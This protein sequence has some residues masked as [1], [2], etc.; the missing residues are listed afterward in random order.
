MASLATRLLLDVWKPAIAESTEEVRITEFKCSG[1][2]PG[3][4]H[5]IQGATNP[6][7]SF[8]TNSSL[9]NRLADKSFTMSGN[10]KVSA[11]S[12]RLPYL[13]GGRVDKLSGYSG[14]TDFAIATVGPSQVPEELRSASTLDR[15]VSWI[16]LEAQNIP[17]LGTPFGYVRQGARVVSHSAYFAHASTVPMIFGSNPQFMWG[18][19]NAD[20][21]EPIRSFIGFICDRH[22]L[23]WADYLGICSGS[24]STTTIGKSRFDEDQVSIPN[25]R[26]V[27][28]QM[29]TTNN[30][31]TLRFYVNGEGDDI[32]I[33]EYGYEHRM[34]NELNVMFAYTEDVSLV[35]TVPRKGNHLNYVGYYKRPSYEWLLSGPF[36]FI[37]SMQFDVTSAVDEEIIIEGV[38]VIVTTK[39]VVV[40]KHSGSVSVMELT[41]YFSTGYGVYTPASPEQLK[42]FKK[43]WSKVSSGVAFRGEIRDMS[44][45]S[46][47]SLRIYKEYAKMRKKACKDND[48]MKR[49]YNDLFKWQDVED[50]L[51]AASTRSLWFVN[52]DSVT[53]APSIALSVAVTKVGTLYTLTKTNG[54][55]YAI[56]AV[57][58][59]GDTA[60]AVETNLTAF[61]VSCR[62]STGS[63]FFTELLQ[64]V[65][66]KL[67]NDGNI[68]Q[69]QI[70]E[71]AV[72][73]SEHAQGSTRYNMTLG[74]TLDVPDFNQ[75]KGDAKVTF[76]IY[77]VCDFGK[78]NAQLLPLF[79]RFNTNLLYQGSK[80][81]LLR[82]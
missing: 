69:S 61:I 56:D 54:D 48:W 81:K 26:L 53:I 35:W 31:R 2:L 15:S 21:V 75:L 77:Q 18:L 49:S 64:L 55:V 6:F 16:G 39:E 28:L 22:G 78:M 58:V 14:T 52:L 68:D 5:T 7:S 32:Y 71:L 20:N 27:T 38:K 72:S 42:E 65:S 63:Q 36:Q 41:D 76:G 19:E 13:P 17:V 74:T 23:V 10:T 50:R 9:L 46:V 59:T 29:G 11:T 4:F 34:R 12:V 70:D 25:H 60:A 44:G 62:F 45:L 79:D 3:S 40:S 57:S 37:T 82:P 47:T 33:C 43:N 1:L 51:N 73:M 66:V 30:L 8:V 67:G 80:I 24:D